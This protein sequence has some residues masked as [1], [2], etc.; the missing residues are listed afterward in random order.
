MFKSIASRLLACIV[1]LGIS[2]LIIAGDGWYALQSTTQKIDAIMLDNV[3]PMEQLKTVSDMYSM[4]IVD[5]AWKAQTQ[6][7]GWSDAQKNVEMAVSTIAKNWQTYSQSGMTAEDK[8]MAAEAAR[9]MTAADAAVSKLNGILRRQDEAAL[10][11]FTAKEMYAA[12][13][14][15][16]GK[17]S[18]LVALQQRVARS[19]GQSAR[20]TS[21]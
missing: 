15:L 10:K 5:T 8:R 6:Q 9:M 12:I 14:P 19:E 2:L 1:A 4:N 21:E 13:D 16:T 20:D 3:A 11:Q 17:I 7:I 18:D